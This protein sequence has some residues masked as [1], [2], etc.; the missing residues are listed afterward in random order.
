MM[1]DQ[2]MY[3]RVLARFRSSYANNGALLRAAL[4]AADLQLA[5]RI[6]HTLK[7]AAAMVEARELRLLA[8][9]IEQN[10]LA[11]AGEAL[12]ERLE[13]E[14]AR[15]MVQVDTLLAAQPAQ[16]PAVGAAAKAIGEDELARLC[17][18]LDLG[19]SAAQELIRENNAGLRALLGAVRMAELETA[20]AAFDFERALDMLT[21]AH[22]HTAGQA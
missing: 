11:G 15:V 4:D 21:V 3:L 1:G 13:T 12:L 14:L 7:G 9:R 19:D 6:A 22:R 18:M 16:A 5:Q 20:V 2:P 8:A 17:G 10:V